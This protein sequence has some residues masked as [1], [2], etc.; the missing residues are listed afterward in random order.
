MMTR[1]V[2]LRPDVSGLCK[3]NE[4]NEWARDTPTYLYIS[5][6]FAGGT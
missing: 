1:S 3:I 4:Y 5:S 6:A 2:P